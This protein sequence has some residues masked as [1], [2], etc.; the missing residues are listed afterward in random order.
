[1]QVSRA[2][3]ATGRSALAAARIATTLHQG[4][5]PKVRHYLAYSQAYS[6]T[7]APLE[8]LKVLYGE[9]LSHPSVVGLVIGTRPDCI[10]EAKLDYLA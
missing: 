6:N 10:D 4:R 3:T 7:Y 8:K 1:M 2:L 5:Y 9:A